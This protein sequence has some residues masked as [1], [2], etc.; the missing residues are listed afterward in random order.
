MNRQDLKEYAL[1][2]FEGLDIAGADAARAK[3]LTRKLEAEVARR[4]F[5]PAAAAAVDDLIRELNAL[6]HSFEPRKTSAGWTSYHEATNAGTRAFFIHVEGGDAA[7]VMVLYHETIETT[8]AKRRAGLSPR[9]RASADTEDEFAKR[10]LALNTG[11]TP[12]R[13]L[14]PNDQL[15]ACLHELEGGISNGGFSTY[16]SNTEGARLSDAARFLD[17]IGAGKAAEIVRD[18]IEL[19]PGRF[20]PAFR[21]SAEVLLDSKRDALDALTTR[22]NASRENIAVLAMRHVSKKRKR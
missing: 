14:A 11:N 22:F 8:I 4:A 17:Q 20:G 3:E 15:I 13:S 21:R 19:F 6:G 18:T 12:Y 16:I 2:V 9:Q 1:A 5:G 10:G 7:G